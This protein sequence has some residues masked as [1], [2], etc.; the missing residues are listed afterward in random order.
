[1]QQLKPGDWAWF[2]WKKNK[3]YGGTILENAPYPLKVKITKT[4]GSEDFC[5]DIPHEAVYGNSGDDLDWAIAKE[6]LYPLKPQ[7]PYQMKP[8]TVM[9]KDN[10]EVFP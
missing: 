3:K 4:Y 8:V 7:K 5:A 1:M 2:D 6:C 9:V 10:E